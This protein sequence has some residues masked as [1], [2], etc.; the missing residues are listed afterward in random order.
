[1][2]VVAVEEVAPRRYRTQLVD[3]EGMESLLFLDVELPL[4]A[5]EIR[6]VHLVGGR[7]SR[8]T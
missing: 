6:I 8:S 4:G 2:S 5:V 3:D 7:D 1:M